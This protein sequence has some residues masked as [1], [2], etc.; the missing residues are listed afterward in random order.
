MLL[1]WHFLRLHLLSFIVWNV[2]CIAFLFMSPYILLVF[3]T[4]LVSYPSIWLITRP[5]N[6][7]YDYY[8]KN[9]GR[10]V[11]SLFLTVTLVDFLVF[12][13]LVIPFS[14]LS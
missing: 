1:H 7:R 10:S 3:L 12:S 8:F 13:G 5:M 2:I 6:K 9:N 14:L 4:K 11:A